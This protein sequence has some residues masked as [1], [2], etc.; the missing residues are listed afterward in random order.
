MPPSTPLPCSSEFAS[1]ED[2]IEQLLNFSQTSDTFQIL[3]GGV[4][5]VDFFTNDPGL[6]YAA[7][8]TE[9]HEFLLSQDIMRLLDFLMRDD[10]DTVEFENGQKPPESLLEYIRQIRRLSLGRAF[11][12]DDSK[13]PKLTRSVAVGMNPKKIHEVRSF[14]D[15]VTRLSSDISKENGKNI[16]HFVDFGSGQNYLGRALASEPYNK[17]VVA[18]EGRANNVDAARGY[19]VK[20]GLASKPVVMRN[21][22]IWKNV[23][24]EAR[25]QDKKND[26]EALAEAVKKL[27]GDDGE[28]YRR[29]GNEEATYTVEQGKGLIQ[30]VSGRLENGDLSDVITKIDRTGLAD[31]S[32]DDSEEQLKMKLMAISIHS[33]GNLSH[34]GIRSLILNPD[35]HAVAIVGCCYNLVTEKL[36]PPTYKHA[37]LRP[38]LQAVNGR[39]VKE[40]D[41]R[42]P[43]GFPMSEKFS[44]YKGEGIRANIT[45]RMMACQAPQNW[46]AVESDG[47][48][49]RHFYRAVLQ[50]I[51]LDRGAVH[52]ILYNADQ[53]ATSGEPAG[54]LQK[55][56]SP[57]AIGTLPKKSYA[58]MTTYVRAAINKLTTST[59]YKK[60][61]D[62]MQ[63]TMVDITDEEIEAYVERFLPRKQELCIVWSFMAFSAGLIEALIVADRWT[64]LREQPEVEDAWVE[65]VFDFK[66]SPR[67]LVVVGVKKEEEK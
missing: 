10:L 53:E 36:G 32:E 26:V 29:I 22:K 6:F 31:D 62:V 60:Y 28:K 1:P 64:F 41:K 35:I 3:C 51:F 20:S 21:K 27:A 54:P 24:E 34:F 46:T 17:R 38:S 42:D 30:Y 57:L 5:V 59:E 9:W 19:D 11:H 37:Y 55:S 48:F 15:Y 56:T 39:V 58:S 61:A 12:S 47:F 49:T 44:T 16:T 43:Q 2:Y 23:L 14:A 52:E 13:L 7:I 25:S 33:C 63:E 8:P 40:S 45:S 66:Q 4:H 18:V 65:A 67:N 50:K